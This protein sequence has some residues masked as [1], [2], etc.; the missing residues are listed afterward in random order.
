MNTLE[1]YKKYTRICLDIVEVNSLDKNFIVNF[2]Q[3]AF[4][5]DVQIPDIFINDEMSGEMT[6]IQYRCLSV[7]R[8]I[9]QTSFLLFVKPNEEDEEDVIFNID[10]SES[11]EIVFDIPL[12]IDD[13]D[14]MND[15]T[16]M[17][18]LEIVDNIIND[19]VNRYLKLKELLNV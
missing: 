16:K 4:L 9:K 18:L 13:Y 8:K 12:D 17:I 7:P 14:S 6:L 5:N 19:I 10:G 11:N 3:D 2:L 15:E 1:F